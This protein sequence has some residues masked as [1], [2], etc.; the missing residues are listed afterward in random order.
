MSNLVGSAKT[1]SA[2]HAKKS[3][4]IAPKCMFRYM[5]ETFYKVAGVCVRN[6]HIRNYNDSADFK[7][8]Y[9]QYFLR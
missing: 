4:R 3:P 9:Y 2:V 7:W 6:F 5:G 8:I 1:R